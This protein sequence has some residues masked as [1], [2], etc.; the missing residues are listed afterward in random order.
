MVTMHLLEFGWG[1][2]E[3]EG[4]D[5]DEEGA[6]F[7]VVTEVERVGILFVWVW[8]TVFNILVAPITVLPVAAATTRA[9]VRL[10]RDSLVR[11]F[12]FM[13]PPFGSLNF[14]T[15]SEYSK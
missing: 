2:G 6:V 3:G 11:F 13:R 4:E 8:A 15:D 14:L 5:E 9:V 12:I 1:V 10:V 7:W